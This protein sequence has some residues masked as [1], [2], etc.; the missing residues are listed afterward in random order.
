MGLKSFCLWCLK[1]GR[2]METITIH[3]H[4]VHYWMAIVCDICWAFACMTAPN[5]L[6]HWSG[7]KVKCDKEHVECDA[8]KR[9]RKSQKSHRSKSHKSKKLPRNYAEWNA[10]LC[11]PHSHLVNPVN[12]L[13]LYLWITLN[14]FLSEHS[15]SQMNCLIPF[16]CHGGCNI[17][18]LVSH[19]HQPFLSY[20][21]HFIINYECPIYSSCLYIYTKFCFMCQVPFMMGWLK[22][23]NTSTLGRVA[24]ACS[25]KI[26]T[27]CSKL[28]FRAGFYPFGSVTTVQGPLHGDARS[29]HSISVEDE[30]V[31]QKSMCW[32]A[33]PFHAPQGYELAI[34][35]T[36][37][38]GV[39]FIM[40]G[41]MLQASTSV[42]ST[43]CCQN[44][45]ID[46][47]TPLVP[48]HWTFYPWSNIYAL[49]NIWRT[50]QSFLLTQT[51]GVSTVHCWAAGRQ[52]TLCC[53]FPVSLLSGICSFR[54]MVVL[55][56]SS[57]HMTVQRGVAF[58]GV[59]RKSWF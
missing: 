19:N 2:N 17:M 47:H 45:N 30:A 13:P 8:H 58:A 10:I 35:R 27:K 6:D 55:P 25:P 49:E 48:L 14:L 12:K 34:S 40:A 7:C 46:S 26:L 4:E 54:V 5:I 29:S 53:A 56:G 33:L 43:I 3:L 57:A 44:A 36:K 28:T 22:Q 38:G 24:C 1:L 32:L 37:R 51:K 41:H 39:E 23:P 50:A 16:I 20:T 15:L 11:L 59:M 18:V 52:S 31:T 9:C 42:I 21:L